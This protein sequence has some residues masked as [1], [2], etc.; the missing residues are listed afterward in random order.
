[1]MEMGIAKG[2]RRGYNNRQV[3]EE[4]PATMFCA[5]G[6][7]VMAR[8]EISKAMLKRLPVYLSYLK[9]LPDSGHTHISAT[10]LASALSMGE[11]QV[12]KDLATVSSGGR[13]KVGYLRESLVADLEEFL[14][15]GNSNNAVIIGAGKLGMALMGYSG[16]AE[17]GLNI[18]AAFD[19][20]PALVGQESSGKAILALEQLSRFCQEQNIKIGVITVPAERAQEVCDRLIEAGI[21]AIWNF[22]PT[23]LDVPEDILV[24]N[25]NMAASLALLSK[26]LKEHM[27]KQGK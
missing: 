16:F 18:V 13:P 3:A 27:G 15:Y 7:S 17:Y 20:N 1:M 22:A 9:S 6:V 24:Q 25:E 10:A 14:G 5:R 8:K 4:K 19:T 23:H 26:H 12:R 11:V 2:A 21:A